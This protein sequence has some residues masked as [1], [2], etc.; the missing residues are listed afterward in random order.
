MNRRLEWNLFSFLLALVLLTFWTGPLLASDGWSVTLPVGGSKNQTARINNR[1]SQPHGFRLDAEGARFLRFAQPVNDVRIP[2]AGSV[3]VS[4]VFDASGLQPGSYP[5]RINVSCN[6]CQGDAGCTQDR[7]VIPVELKVVEPL[8]LEGVSSH[9]GLLA[10]ESQKAF[11]NTLS[12][13]ERLDRARIPR[14]SGKSI[15][16]ELETSL[17]YRSLRRSLAER[18]E[19]A[20][21]SGQLGPDNDPD[22]FFIQDEYLRAL[23]NDRLEIRV[24][25]SIY[26]I[27]ES[28]LTTEIPTGNV[29]VLERLRAGADPLTLGSLVQLH[30]SWVSASSPSAPAGNTGAQGS[31]FAGFWFQ[32]D[33]RVVT[34][35]N[36]SLPT[37][38]LSYTWT[39]GDGGTSKE[40]DPKHTYAKYGDY[41]VC[42][43][44]TD[45][46]GCS[47]QFCQF[48]SAEQKDSDCCDAN[49]RVKEKWTTYAGDSRRFKSVLWQT[50]LP[51]VHRWGAKT[52]NYVK[53]SKGNWSRSSAETISVYGGGT[54]YGGDDRGARCAVPVVT[55]WSDVRNNEQR[56]HFSLGVGGKFWTKRKSLAS[57]HSVFFEGKE[58]FGTPLYLTEDC[59][60]KREC[61]KECREEKR[62]CKTVCKDSFQDCRDVCKE[63]KTVCTESC[64][65]K[66]GLKK[67]RCKKECRVEKR[68][69]KRECRVTKRECKETCSSSV[70]VC[71]EACK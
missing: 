26:Q 51:F 60:R 15:L 56:A 24:G 71:K 20:A 58:I 57:L 39:F 32:V 1:C 23:L 64:S 69:C 16:D 41:N 50:N 38:G 49:D 28:G 63:E 18:E 6:D 54:L 59:P 17:S 66:K 62:G 5:G 10:F 36:K 40:M 4:V 30:Q 35:T 46:A 13:L 47:N 12:T 7:N 43:Q 67:W 9:D 34:F 3:D 14:P 68:S 22:S 37:S 52:I 8:R 27:R 11:E 55:N 70:Q 33:D 25:R 48:V 65:G 2:A 45:S 53:D 19:R 44:V 42:L 61:K 31:C 21:A 29:E